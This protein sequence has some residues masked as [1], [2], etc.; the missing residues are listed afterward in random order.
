[1]LMKLSIKR[2]CDEVK[3]ESPPTPTISKSN[4]KANHVIDI[5]KQPSK[6]SVTALSKKAWTTSELFVNHNKQ[7]MSSTQENYTETLTE[8]NSDLRKVGLKEDVKQTEGKI[9]DAISEGSPES[10]NLRNIN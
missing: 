1:M 6:N 10:G 7:H 5:Q 9:V 4:A 8:L 2:K 3:K